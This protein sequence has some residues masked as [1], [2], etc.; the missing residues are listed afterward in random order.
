MSFTFHVA[1]A[2]KYYEGIAPTFALFVANDAYA[3][4]ATKAFEFSAQ[5]VVGG[6]FVLCKGQNISG[7]VFYV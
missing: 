1:F 4:D 6:G 5:V 2:L 3:L 7:N